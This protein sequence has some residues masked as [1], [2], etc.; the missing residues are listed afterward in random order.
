MRGMTLLPLPAVIVLAVAPVTVTVLLPLPMLIVSCAVRVAPC[1]Q[2]QP[3]P[4]GRQVLP[5][6]GALRR[7]GSLRQPIS[8]CPRRARSGTNDH[9]HRLAEGGVK[10]FFILLWQA[11][12]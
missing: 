3:V 10:T 12:V 4:A 11:N 6:P 7:D 5:R 2:T 8:S 9:V 1:A